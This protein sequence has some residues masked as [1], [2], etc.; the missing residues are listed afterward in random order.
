MERLRR[1]AA[2]LVVERTRGGQR[3]EGR[4]EAVGLLDRRRRDRRDGAPE[5]DGLPVRLLDHV[6][7]D[8]AVAVAG[9]RA[10]EYGLAGV[11]AER[12]A[13]RPHR[14]AQGPV[15]HHHVAPYRVHDLAPVDG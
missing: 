1:F 10:D 3:S 9:Y 11:V 15:A 5:V 4:L 8:E 12:A 2:L 14:L 6:G 13:Q 7:E